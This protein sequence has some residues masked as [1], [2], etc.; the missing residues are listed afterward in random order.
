MSFCKIKRVIAALFLFLLLAASSAFADAWEADTSWYDDYKNERGT[1]ENPFLISSP[2]ELAGLAKLVNVE[3]GKSGKVDF[4]GKYILLTRDINLENKEWE[5]I[6]WKLSYTENSMTGMFAQKEFAG[7]DGDFNGG[8]HTISGLMIATCEYVHVYNG[9]QTEAVGLFGYIGLRGAVRNLT[10]K[11]SVNATLSEGVGGIAGW[12]DGRIEN[13]VTDVEVRAT[14]SKRG[15]AGGI[16]GLN[17]GG[18][19]SDQATVDNP[20]DY[21]IIRNNV[22]LGSV[23]AQPGSFSYAGGVVGFSNWYN[24]KVLNNVAMSP[25]IIANMDAGGIFGGFNSYVTADC[26]SAAEK[27]QASP[28]YVG[29]IVG[30]FGYGT[31]N[32]YWLKVSDDQPDVANGPDR[33]TDGKVTDPA[34][35]PVASAVMESECL[36][37]MKSGETRELRISSYPP[38]ADASGLEYTWSVDESKLEI[39]SGQGTSA[40]TVRAKEHTGSEAAYATVSASVKG[41]LG[42]TE[43]SSGVYES[44]FDTEVSLEGCLKIVSGTIPVERITAYGT[45]QP[46]KE[47]ESAVLGVSVSPSDADVSASNI[48]WT[49]SGVSGAAEADDIIMEKTSDGGLKI[50]LRTGH[51]EDYSYTFTAALSDGSLSD[52]ITVV[53]DVVDDVDISGFIPTGDAVA[54]FTPAA[55]AVGAT[56]DMAEETAASMRADVSVFRISSSGVLYLNTSVVNAALKDAAERDQVEITAAKPLPVFSAAITGS[57]RIAAIGMILS[58]ETLMSDKAGETALVMTRADG[59]GEFFT[60]AE[61]QDA[62]GD[63]RFTLQTM[64]DA[65]MAPGTA[66]DP[67]SQYKLVMYIQDN[68]GFDMNEADGEI[69]SAVAAVSLAEEAESVPASSGGGGGGCNAGAGALALLAVMPLAFGAFRRKY[70]K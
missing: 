12:A 60:Y 41:L 5:P 8:G 30:A 52:Q 57:D 24:G 67:D 62:I 65:V 3:Y 32:C 13:C 23:Y 49:L 43:P 59:T 33:T 50:T 17:G 69:I 56:S 61:D 39:V 4:K 2:E 64:D 48:E 36:K 26:V 25:E 46:L 38:T 14:S 37:T 19:T 27:V 16:A 63:K 20:A 45:G 7:F 6:G 22:T 9:T 47:G 70:G 11:G 10:V 31:Q 68:G 58:G 1:E 34:Q 44:N 29:G 40:L 54:S 35:L 66:I 53:G 21:V 18:A 55:K 51:E 42:H 15:Y 28:G